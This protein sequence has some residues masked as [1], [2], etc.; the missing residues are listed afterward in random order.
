MPRWRLCRSLRRADPPVVLR[1]RLGDGRDRIFDVLRRR[2]CSQADSHRRRGHA[3]SGG[4]RGVFGSLW[5]DRPQEPRDPSITTT[6]GLSSTAQD[7]SAPWRAC[8]CLRRVR[9]EH[10]GFGRPAGCHSACRSDPLEP[11]GRAPSF[12]PS[13][14]I[15]ARPVWPAE[16]SRPWRLSGDPPGSWH[17]RRWPTE[18]GWRN[19][20]SR[21]G[22]RDVARL[23]RPRQ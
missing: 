5:P 1:M 7:R 19:V 23:V 17:C 8:C 4:R 10:P 12:P 15:L 20:G 14:A 9:D 6:G 13:P 18:G 2:G 21:I 3:S 11:R 16:P 22:S